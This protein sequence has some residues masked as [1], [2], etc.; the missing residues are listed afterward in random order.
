MH[1]SHD[2]I[3]ELWRT[4]PKLMML[5]IHGKYSG[6]TIFLH[7][8]IIFISL[9]RSAGWFKSYFENLKLDFCNKA[10]VKTFYADIITI[11]ETKHNNNTG[12]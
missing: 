9:G 11:Q 4:F 5:F 1:P 12:A 2:L 10:H 7:N 6:K 3:L 8:F